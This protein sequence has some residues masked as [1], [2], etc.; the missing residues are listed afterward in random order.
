[1][2][3]VKQIAEFREKY[4]SHGGNVLAT[5]GSV[6]D[7]DGEA[8]LVGVGKVLYFGF[9]WFAFILGISN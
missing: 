9:G 2:A 7:P 3:T 5:A 8:V 4:V 1:M 6:N